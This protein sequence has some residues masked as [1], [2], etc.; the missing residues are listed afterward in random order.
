[1]NMD[2]RI[3]KADF[4]ALKELFFDTSPSDMV[5]IY[6]SEIAIRM[7]RDFGERGRD[8]L[9]ELL[10]AD[11]TAWERRAGALW[12]L[13][14]NQ[15]ATPDIIKAFLQNLDARHNAVIIG[16]VEGLRVFGVDIGQVKV[17]ALL[18]SDCAAVRGRAVEYCA[19]LYPE[20]CDNVLIAGIFDESFIVRMSAVDA[21][22]DY[23]LVHLVSHVKALLHREAHPDVIAA[24][25]QT[26]ENSG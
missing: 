1:M 6:Y 17:A 8:Y 9:L 12:G 4:H 25:T 14:Y 18:K 22:D 13:Q 16:S 24:A 15:Q 21:I 2:D 5:D 20:T 3:A 19:A 26:V 11:G 7:V 23:A 10:Q